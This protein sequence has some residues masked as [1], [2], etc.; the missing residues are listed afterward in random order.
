MN[1]KQRSEFLYKAA[2]E[3]LAEAGFSFKR[4]AW[5]LT[6]RRCQEAIELGLSGVLA[7]LGVHYPKNHDQAV[8]LLRIL[9]SQGVK[10]ADDRKKIESISADLSRKR[11]PALHQEEGYDKET[12]MMAVDNAKWVLGK[13]KEINQ[14][15]IEVLVKR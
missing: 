14:K 15:L 9:E 13:T 4:E 5:G 1:N 7:F 10:L 2:W 12:A 3:S 11:G 8:L 6:V